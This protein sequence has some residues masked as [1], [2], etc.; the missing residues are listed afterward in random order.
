[1]I[2]Q[3]LSR[4][5]PKE[6]PQERRIT[7]S[8]WRALDRSGWLAVAATLLVNVLILT[9]AASP[10][11]AVV[12]L[13]VLLL[14]PGLLTL[15][16][17]HI[18]RRPGADTLL[19][20]LAIS[21]LWLLAISLV[22]AVAPVTGGLSSR[23]CL[24][25]FD[26]V[27]AALTVAVLVRHGRGFK[28]PLATVPAPV[29]ASQPV[30]VD[31]PTL[32]TPVT[33]RDRSGRP[34]LYVR[35]DDKV[36]LRTLPKAALV[37]AG[38]AALAV[39]LAVAGATRLNAGGS[40]TLSTLALAAGA[41]ALL[42]VTLAAHGQPGSRADRISQQSAAAVVFLLALA[43]LF[44]TSLRGVGPTGH[45]IKIEF[46][47]FQETLASGSWRPGGSFPDYRSC[48]S[49]TTL[50]SFL[51][52]M[53]GVAPLDVFRICYQLICAAVPVAVLL[54]ARRVLGTRGATLAAGL[55]IAFPAF[56]N[57][58][59]ML[60]R[61]EPALLFF[62]VA[63][64]AIVER[65]GSRLQR[66]AL[67]AAMLAGITV[68]HY[69]STY[70]AAGVIVA[71]WLLLSARRTV[72][73]STGTTAT[74]DY[75]HALTLPLVLIALALPVGWSAVTGS[76]SNLLTSM[77]ST[78]SAFRDKLAA[79]SDAV[80]YSFLPAGEPP[81]TD[82]QALQ[83]YATRSGVAGA[84]PPPSCVPQ[85]LPAD[86]LPTGAAGRALESIGAAPTTINRWSRTGA[87]VLFELG[88]VLGAF[89]LWVRT[90]RSLRSAH[91]VAVLCGGAL[92]ML[93]ATVFLPQLSV[94]Y[95]LLRLYQQ[96]LVMLAPAAML[97]L[98]T[99]LRPLGRW[100]AR[101]GTAVIVTGCLI[102]TSGV[103]PQTL[104]EYQPQ[105]SLNNAGPYYHAYYAAA[106]DVAA[107]R[108][109]AANIPA[110]APLIADG[111][112]SAMLRSFPGRDVL[113]GLVP[114]RIPPE[115]YLQVRVSGPDRAEAVGIWRER[116]LRYT[117]PLHCVTANRPL[118]HAED[119][120]R[121]YGPAR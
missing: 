61:Q 30:D 120:Y 53:L 15:R 77:H 113:E 47:V 40:G 65:Q 16:A 100:I 74:G 107:A 37:A 117:F 104:G 81:L 98:T 26:A 54:V 71:A 10:V 95:G 116:V 22:L 92:V 35:G 45:D 106:G 44:A 96:M 89:L 80:G 46:R 13:P 1:M 62:A 55:F 90:R 76:G 69:S 83:D 9:G 31:Q 102:T 24:V 68:T 86:S 21:L 73:R 5:D 36:T 66:T 60:N 93:G 6:P 52:R 39:A 108:W 50:P 79:S 97:A 58:L 2:T 91:T 94:D 88:A 34:R 118:L 114:G 70:I 101:A 64:L 82:E 121:I 84:V 18:L 33:E 29:A 41:C 85:L 63:M 115:S 8:P 57:D 72:R 51:C 103:L 78:V 14:T 49:I 42:L 87:V 56:V 28:A 12:V 19:H 7:T 105:L 11:R 75:A 32:I 25:A 112:A 27:M 4:V 119:N 20:A 59:P 38:L 23:G 99:A 67:C 109:S 3:V 110:T 43:V 48:L 17:M 111:A